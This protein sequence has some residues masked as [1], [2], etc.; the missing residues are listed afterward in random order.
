MTT[1]TRFWD[2]FAERYSRRPVPNAE[3]YERKLDIT[4]ARLRP[5]DVVLDL[6]CGTGSLALELAPN[7]DRVHA[8]D[9]SS[10]MIRI[11]RR[12]AADAGVDNIT[13]H[14]STLEGAT[15]FEPG[16]FDGICAYN[17]LH[18]VDDRAAT[19]QRTFELLRPGGFF[20]SSTAVLGESRVP[21][22]P[23][24]ALLRWLGK[25]P[26]VHVCSLNTLLNE[27]RE[28]GFVDV[29]TRDVGAKKNTA[30]VVARKP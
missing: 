14:Q 16:Q 6:G 2:D 21:H 10:E 29:S 25:A 24:L 4:K 8:L 17:V 13:F 1:N 9:Y 12:K 15:W 5:T 27:I 18:L 22:G 30:F 26:R 3:A 23:V 28:A 19:L 7:V 11:A 20:V